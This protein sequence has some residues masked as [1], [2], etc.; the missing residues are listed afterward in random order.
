M[1]LI[2]FSCYA[3]KIRDIQSV[4][5]N[6]EL[7][8]TSTAFWEYNNWCRRQDQDEGTV[9]SSLRGWGRSDVPGGF[10]G[11]GGAGRN[12]DGSRQ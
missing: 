12:T 2:R 9:T 10:R 3:C 8:S 6:K 7:Y 5:C 4:L 11:C 1:I